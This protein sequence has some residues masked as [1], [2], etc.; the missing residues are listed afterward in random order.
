MYLIP[1]RSP[2]PTSTL[3]RSVRLAGASLAGLLGLVLVAGC[4]RPAAQAEPTTKA[5][6]A[7]PPTV[8]IVHPE[9]KTVR[10]AIKR[11]GYNIEAYQSTPL[12]PRISGYVRKWNVDIGARVS[13]D[14]VMAELFVPEMEVDLQ[15]KE[16]AV[17]Q[18]EAE[19][20]QARAAVLRSQAELD[21][22]KLQYERLAKVGKS[23][24]IDQENVEET[25]FGYAAAKAGLAKAEAD[26]AVAAARLLVVQ[27]ARDYAKTL[28]AYAQIRAPFDGV[29]TQRTITEGDFL[30]PVVG[31][32]GEA[33]FIVDQVD[34]VRVFLNVPE[35]EAVWIRDGAKATVRNQSLPGQV[36][37]GTV[38][39]TSRSLSPSTRTLR[40]EID[41][42][43]PKGNLLPG[44][45]VDVTV[46]VEHSDVWTLPASAVV[47]E[48]DRP[49]CFRHE[50][51]K[52]VRM[53]LQLALRGDGVIEIL[54]KQVKPAEADAV[55]TWEDFTGQEEIVKSNATSLKDGQ[56]I[57]IAAD[58]K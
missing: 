12:Y 21:R 23:G 38:T 5:P 19:I 15:Q 44:M 49:Y 47:T 17:I 40:T 2:F 35:L 20:V 50:N 29:V 26:V 51:G 42:P 7:A 43:N 1:R 8:T 54:K 3:P 24:V 33:I 14:S 11:P 30:Q 22:T 52:A 18:A 28:L 6:D 36:F 39:R 31:K 4:N 57:V 46:M 34:P 25:R 45:Y 13:R 32:K 37:H 10:R 27:K 48:D 53:P 16:A 56:A 58:A 9:R 41:L 55:G